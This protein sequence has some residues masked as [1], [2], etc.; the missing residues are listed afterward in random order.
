M[1]LSFQFSCLFC[2]V[3][4]VKGVLNFGLKSYLL[5]LRPNDN[6]IIYSSVGHCTFQILFSGSVVMNIISYSLRFVSAFV[7]FKAFP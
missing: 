6:K 5:A 1:F 2:F 7:I 3:I 4:S